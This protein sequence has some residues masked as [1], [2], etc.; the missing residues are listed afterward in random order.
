MTTAQELMTEKPTTVRSDSPIREAA[1]LLQTVA[2]RHLPVLDAHGRL[3]GML[4]DRDLHGV[5]VPR[6]MAPE[7]A[8]ELRAAFD[9]TVATI[10]STNVITAGADASLGFVVGLMLENKIGAV[11]IV[12]RGGAVVG[13][14]SYVDV[15][16]HMPLYPE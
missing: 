1:H 12:S 5:L 14:V 2:V 10:M 4:S 9:A 3:V 6:L 8:A 15:L 16:R 7:H 13:I 11:P